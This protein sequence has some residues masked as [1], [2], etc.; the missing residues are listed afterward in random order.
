[1]FSWNIT[2]SPGFFLSFFNQQWPQYTVVNLALP[3]PFC[4]P[5]ESL[6]KFNLHLKWEEW[7][8]CVVLTSP[9][10]VISLLYNLN[11]NSIS[12]SAT[13]CTAKL[14]GKQMLGIWNWSVVQEMKF[15]SLPNTLE[16]KH[17]E[18]AMIL[19][20]TETNWLYNDPPLWTFLFLFIH[21]IRYDDIVVI[22]QCVKHLW[23]SRWDWLTAIFMSHGPH[24]SH[25]HMNYIHICTVHWNCTVFIWHVM[26]NI[27]LSSGDSISHGIKLKCLVL[28]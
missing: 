25:I 27:I 22:V 7:I 10:L 6:V 1:M 17:R 5:P 4:F 26:R 16:A 23:V 21:H 2:P 12:P 8:G 20:F 11:T 14:F 9:L 28:N 3:P 18:H 19:N 15:Y 24:N 13:I